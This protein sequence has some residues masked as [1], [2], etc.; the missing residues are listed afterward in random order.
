MELDAVTRAFKLSYFVSE[1]S[2]L[3]TT[4]AYCYFQIYNLRV[5]RFADPRPW[6]RYKEKHADFVVHYN[7]PIKLNSASDNSCSTIIEL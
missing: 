4:I 2:V 3:A 1:T 5:R 6:N 7:D